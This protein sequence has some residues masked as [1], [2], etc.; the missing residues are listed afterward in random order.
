LR[1]FPS[2]KAA[3]NQLWKVHSNAR[4]A[5]MAMTKTS[6]KNNPPAQSARWNDPL[7]PQQPLVSARWLIG[8]FLLAV[9]AAAVCAYLALCLL[10]WQGQWQILFHPSRVITATPANVGIHFDEI[11]FNATETG[12][13]QL[14]GW[15]VPAE[16]A[17]RY[18]K[19]TV[20]YLHDGAGS[21][22][23]SIPYLSLLH[24]IGVNV[25][26]FDYRGFGQSKN[27]HPSE[28]RL[29]RD[30]EAALTYLAD[31]RHLPMNSIVVYGK[32][33]GASI[34]AD[35]AAQHGALPGIILDD[36]VPPALRQIQTDAR[37]KLLPIKLLSHDRFELET[38]LQQL[39]TPKLFLTD[40]PGTSERDPPVGFQS[41]TNPKTVVYLKQPLASDENSRETISRF[42]GELN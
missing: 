20:L 29:K 30:S 16:Q 27:I 4:N 31:I 11:R 12:E 9:G 21:M 18:A 24:D 36:P 41:A 37:T 13:L 7:A 34:A 33:L 5:L 14:A 25:F 1:S 6:S 26:I 15:W 17:S 19:T 28:A 38:K 40:Q 22:S 32:G 23:D 3:L 39:K 42:I 35:M 10:F 2:K 8:A